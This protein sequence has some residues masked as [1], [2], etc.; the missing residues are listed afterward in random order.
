MRT[1]LAIAV[2]AALGSGCVAYND[3]CKPLVDNPEEKI[4]KLG[5]VIYMDRPNTRHANNGMG[6]V[7]AESFVEVFANTAQ[8]AE[9]AVLNGG[10]LRAE[11]VCVTRNILRNGDDVTRGLVSEILLFA[12]IVQA[13]DLREDEVIA[14]F[15]HS[16]ERLFP[17]GTN[18]SA[19]AGSFL[20]VSK[21]VA[22]TVDCSRPAQDRITALAINGVA[23]TKPGNPAKRYRTA[24]SSFILAGNDG[25]TMLAG[26]GDD[27]DRRPAQAQ[28]LGGVDSAIAADYL[29]R[30]FGGTGTITTDRARVSFVGCAAPVPPTN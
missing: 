19:P 22:M 27:P 25:Y 23:I 6:Q 2:A 21:Q 9:F 14:M 26:K 20:Q 11:G 16:V 13:A 29:K 5:E 10:S 4:A 7:F 18:I 3:Q 30:T 24:L 12:N 8:P 15:E 17:Q 1:A 28:K